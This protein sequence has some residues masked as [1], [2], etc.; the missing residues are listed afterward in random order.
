MKRKLFLGIG[1]LVWRLATL[2][3]RAAGHVFFLYQDGLIVAML[4]GLTIA[5]MMLLALW[6][7][8]W[9]G[10]SGSQRYEAAAL[11][12]IPGMALD[13]LVTQGFATV[14]PNMA[15][16]AA[17]SFGAWLLIAYASVLLAAFLPDAQ[18]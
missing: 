9:Q 5:A 11:L 18:D 14:F 7:F 13:G 2:A 1:C 4:W 12:V 15:A 16:D 17:G 3:F 8:R 6:I 10:L